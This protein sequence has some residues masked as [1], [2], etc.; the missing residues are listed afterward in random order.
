VD[1][2]V[3]SRLLSRAENRVNPTTNFDRLLGQALDAEGI[4]PSVI[5]TAAAHQTS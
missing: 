5:P 2:D 3:A 1:A 4:A